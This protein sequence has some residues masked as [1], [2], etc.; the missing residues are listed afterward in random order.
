MFIKFE[1]QVSPLKLT[2]AIVNC[3]PDPSSIRFLI[4]YSACVLFT[5][6]SRCEGLVIDTFRVFLSELFF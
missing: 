2:C 5:F 1:H 6:L 4:A 3:M